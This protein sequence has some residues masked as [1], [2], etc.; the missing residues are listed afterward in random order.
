MTVCIAALFTWNYAP[1][2]SPPELGVGA[3]AASDRMI[4]AADIQYEPLQQ[5]AAFF[6]NTI[7]LV[8]GDI[9]IHSQAILD[10][11]KEIRDR[12]L[13]P[14]DIAQIYGRAVQALNRKRAENE[15]LGPL[16]LNTDTFLAQQKEMSESFVNMI[17]GQLQNHRP[18]DSEAL[19]VGTDGERS[20]IYSVDAYGNDTNLNAIGF[21]AI[22]I[23]AWHAKSRLMQAGHVSARMIAHTLAAVFAAKKNAEIAPG[24]GSYTDINIVLKNGVF[25]LWERV[26]PELARLYR[27]YSGELEKLSVEIVTEIQSFIDTPQ[28]YEKENADGTKGPI[29]KHAQADAGTRPDAPEAARTNEN[30]G[31]EGSQKAAE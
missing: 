30:G 7:V 27:K 18:I 9:A 25:P 11:A 31:Q 23:G 15:I 20:H 29:G 28:T 5:K 12:K 19:V 6:G 10:T 26:G 8:A 17:T 16:G 22:G 3:V 24:V 1:V 13:P 14:H 4:T 21:G 2:G